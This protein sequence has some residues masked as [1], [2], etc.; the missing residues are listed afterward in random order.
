MRP[1]PECLER[2]SFSLEIIFGA[3]Q[4]FTVG[5]GELLRA[6]LAAG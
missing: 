3:A 4:L 6:L 1:E 2:K 5:C